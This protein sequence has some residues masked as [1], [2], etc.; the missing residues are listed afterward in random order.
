MDERKAPP[1]PEDL[2]EGYSAMNQDDEHEYWVATLIERIARLEQEARE[3][4]EAEVQ[5]NE[6]V[7]KYQSDSECLEQELN[8]LR[9]AWRTHVGD[10]A[11]NLTPQAL[12]SLIEDYREEARQLREEMKALSDLHVVQMHGMM[13]RGDEAIQENA[14]LE[15][16]LAEAKRGWD[17]CIADL[18]AAA[19]I[20]RESER[21]LAEA[22]RKA[23]AMRNSIDDHRKRVW[24]DGPV[25]HD[26]DLSLYAEKEKP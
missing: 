23:E 18:R 12:V 9:E 14:A 19:E 20:C 4:A 15:A 1:I 2:Q 25:L 17:S 13:T 16:Q 26:A 21:K 22:K 6:M 7:G 11:D 3:D 24:G 10:G 5:I 8:G